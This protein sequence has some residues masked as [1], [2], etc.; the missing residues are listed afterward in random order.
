MSDRGRD[1]PLQ[2]LLLVQMG[3][4]LLL[5]TALFFVLD[6]TIDRELYRRLDSE[7]LD[8]ARSY[9]VLVAVGHEAD[10]PRAGAPGA[11]F[12]L[13]VLTLAA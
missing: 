9:A 13:R 5:F 6:G 2:H 8:R 7:L 11:R 10:L 4:L 1:S 3:G 12:D